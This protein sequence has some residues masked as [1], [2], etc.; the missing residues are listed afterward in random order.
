MT[1][2]ISSRSIRTSSP[3]A[4]FTSEFEGSIAMQQAQRLDHHV[5]VGR[6]ALSDAARIPDLAHSEAAEMATVELER[7]LACVEGLAPA[8][9]DLPTA[10]PLWTVRQVVAH[11]TGAA[12]AYARWSEFRRQTSPFVQRPY[13]QAG[14]SLLDA[15]NQI[16]VDDRR[17]ATP[18]ALIAELREVGPRAIATRKRLPAALRT[19]RLPLPLL[20]VVP[21]G[22]LTD[23]IYTRDMWMHRLDLCRATGREMIQTPQHD[24]WV[25]ALVVRD[26]A[27][28]LTPKLAG[29]AVVYDLTG[30]AGGGFHL[31]AHASPGARI[32]ME[33]LDFH[34]QASGRLSAKELSAR[35]SCSGDE[36]LARL[37]LA[38]TR[39]PY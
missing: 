32:T 24:G 15:L 6:P 4:E 3:L 38:N 33:V 39:V 35:A 7:F 10:C 26:L 34:L 30:I 18:A 20:G 1:R 13:R 14:L 2:P 27:R 37:A 17:A 19:V 11:V 36:H 31:G 22:Y 9:W 28:K 29:Q 8:E 25:T 21:V 12:A 16:Q 23:L 5:A